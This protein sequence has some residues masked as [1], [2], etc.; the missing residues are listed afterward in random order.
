MQCRRKIRRCLGGIRLRQLWCA[1]GAQVHF[2]RHG[3]H[4]LGLGIESVDETFRTIWKP[5]TA[6]R[7]RTKFFGLG[8]RLA[9]D[10]AAAELPSRYERV[11]GFFRRPGAYGRFKEVLAA[12]GCLEQWYA[13]E[14]EAA[15]KAL[16]NWCSENKIEITEKDS[17][18]A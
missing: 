15:E 18:S 7:H 4:L 6:R 1:N 12:E 14:A 9:L 16:K 11:Q 8:S 5:Q 2:A 10:F 17:E 3:C 13:F